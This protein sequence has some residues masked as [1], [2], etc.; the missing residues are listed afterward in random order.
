MPSAHHS[1]CELIAPQRLC[2]EMELLPLQQNCTPKKVISTLS[3]AM[4]ANECINHLQRREQQVWPL[5]TLP[6]SC[7]AYEYYTW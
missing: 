3:G 2:A 5:Q 4:L 6:V 7:F 1:P